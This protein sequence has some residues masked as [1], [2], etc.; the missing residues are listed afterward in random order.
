[1]F[2]VTLKCW[3]LTHH[4][5]GDWQQQKFCV[6]SL[7]P[8]PTRGSAR[9]VCLGSPL[10]LWTTQ[11][12]F[13]LLRRSTQDVLHKYQNRDPFVQSLQRHHNCSRSDKKFIKARLTPSLPQPVKFSAGKVLTYALANSIFDGPKRTNLISVFKANFSIVHFDRISFTRSCEGWKSR[14]NFKFGTFIVVVFLSNGAASTAVK[15]LMI[16][17]HTVIKLHKGIVHWYAHILS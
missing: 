4:Q 15:G 3:F 8:F 1:M 17:T 10:I 2:W 13:L 9:L 11:W 5:A 16:C 12:C 14:N 6:Q 7:I